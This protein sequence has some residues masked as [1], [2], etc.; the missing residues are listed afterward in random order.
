MTPLYISHGWESIKLNCFHLTSQ[1]IDKFF[2]L[3]FLLFND[4]LESSNKFQNLF[5][6]ITSNDDL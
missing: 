2:L 3:V 1:L 5:Y 4:E 6:L